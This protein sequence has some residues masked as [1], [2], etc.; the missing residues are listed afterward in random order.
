MD[1]I[2]IFGS[3]A[4]GRV[5]LDIFLSQ[6]PMSSFYFV[7]DSIEKQGQLVN[8]VEIIS[9]EKMFSQSQNPS[10][11]VAIG[12]NDLREK[13][14]NEFILKKCNL[15]NA[16]HATAIVVPSA[17]IGVGNMIG[18]YSIVNSNARLGNGCII[19]TNVII[20]HDTL[21]ENYS[22][23]SPGAVIGGRVI[24]REKAFISSNS[25][26]HARVEIGSKSIIGMSSV[27]TKNVE[28]KEMVY[29]NP[30][31]FIRKVTDSDWLKVL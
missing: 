11:H 27:V 13:I 29:G 21:V 7:D 30:A 10:I 5:V 20:E 15:I 3:G 8:G 14:S 25:T 16:I 28:N 12:N 19:N 31:K 23:I 22:S 24:I 26:I 17:K 9:Q 4:Q 1:K 6:Y 2:Y 18:I